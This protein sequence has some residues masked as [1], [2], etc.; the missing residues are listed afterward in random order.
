M[1]R[2]FWRPEVCIFTIH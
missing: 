2:H 1:I